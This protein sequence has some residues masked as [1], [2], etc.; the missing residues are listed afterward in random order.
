MTP[1]PL[2]TVDADRSR[3]P[4][5]GAVVEFGPLELLVESV[6][7]SD[8]A[9]VLGTEI[10]LVDDDEFLAVETLFLNTSD[11]YLAVDVDRYDVAH[12]TGVA[13][14]IEPFAGLAASSFGGWAFAPGERRRVRLHYKIPPR[15]ADA[16][17]RGSVRIR[18][19]P[20]EAAAVAALEIDLTSVTADPTGLEGSLSAPVR[21]VGEGTAASGLS[22]TVRDVAVPVA[23]PNWTPP[24]GREHL[25]LSLSVTNEIEPGR[26]IVVALGRFGGLALADPRGTAFTEEVRFDGTLADERRYDGSSALLPGETREGVLAIPVPVEAP[27]LYLFWTPPVALWEVGTGVAINRFVWRLR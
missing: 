27:P 5:V 9:T 26:P 23:V 2:P 24:P 8:R 18:S 22:V 12:G 11:R 13:E 20:D 17:L 16:R 14:P 6:E 1:A 21:E 10:R 4:P 19:L 7:R 15:A 3:L 25:A